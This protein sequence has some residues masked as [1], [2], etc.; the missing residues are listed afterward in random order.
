[1]PQLASSACL[2]LLPTVAARLLPSKP[3]SWAGNW[4]ARCGP[5]FIHVHAIHTQCWHLQQVT[6]S[7]ASCQVTHGQVVHMQKLA[8][9][10][11]SLQAHAASRPPSTT[12]SPSYLSAR[13]T[14]PCSISA[15]QL[16]TAWCLATAFYG[17]HCPAAGPAV[18]GAV[19]ALGGSHCRCWL[20][21]APRSATGSARAVECCARLAWDCELVLC[22]QQLA[23]IYTWPSR[24]PGA[25]CRLKSG[26][27]LS[28]SRLLYCLS[29]M[30]CFLR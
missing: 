25:G 8:P 29:V 17:C 3:A 24:G 14:S 4:W 26:H 13:C 27:S 23:N 30:F 9:S 16:P 12:S 19:Q 1:M 15:C 20:M 7:L 10:C 21:A 28:T 18:P 11:C 6:H 5:W 22:C 2:L